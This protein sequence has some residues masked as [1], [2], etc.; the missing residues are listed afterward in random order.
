MATKRKNLPEDFQ[1]MNQGEMEDILSKH[2][3]TFD[4]LK[5]S[6]IVDDEKMETLFERYN[7]KNGDKMKSN[8][9]NRQDF[10][11]SFIECLIIVSVEED[12]EGFTFKAT[13]TFA[14]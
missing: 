5:Q 8:K 1:I 9:K 12:G 6:L 14:I 2:G 7:K 4:D 13:S 10:I 11:E 3:K